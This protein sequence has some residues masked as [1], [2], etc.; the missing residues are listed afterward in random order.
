MSQSIKTKLFFDLIPKNEIE[1]FAK[2]MEERKYQSWVD[3]YPQNLLGIFGAFIYFAGYGVEAGDITFFKNKGINL[4]I[5]SN[6]Y[7]SNS[8][9]TT[10]LCS[11]CE[12]RNM[13]LIRGLVA[14]GAN[15]N[16]EDP[17]GFTPIEFLLIGHRIEDIQDASECETFIKTL[18]DLGAQKSV[19]KDVVDNSCKEY[20]KKSVYMAKFLSEV[21]T[22]TPTCNGINN[23]INR[24]LNK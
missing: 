11:A 19:R 20:N 18:L 15:I 22:R 7:P 4:N 3:K 1:K 17:N 16:D 21:Q 12:F 14:S 13:N 2:D 24:A 8:G 23:A 9:N 6:A 10:P 5:A